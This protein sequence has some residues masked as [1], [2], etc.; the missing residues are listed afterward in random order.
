MSSIVAGNLLWLPTGTQFPVVRPDSLAT[1]WHWRIFERDAP[2]NVLDYSQ[3][4][5]SNSQR[6]VFAPI[7][8]RYQTGTVYRVRILN[9]ALATVVEG[10]FQI[11]KA[12]FGADAAVDFHQINMSLRIAAGLAGL[13]QKIDYLEHDPITGIPMRARITIYDDETLSAVLATY[14]LRRRLNDVAQVVGEVQYRTFLNQDLF[15]ACDQS[16]PSSGEM[17]S[18][19]PSNP[20]GGAPPPVE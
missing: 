17:S 6:W 1:D 3:T 14:D 10:D 4:L 19:D 2:A 9:N 20:S 8:N 13:N 12:V 16:A 5:I 7:D 15:D 11:V 18:G